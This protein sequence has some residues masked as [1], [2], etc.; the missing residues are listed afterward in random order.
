MPSS[1]PGGLGHAGHWTEGEILGLWAS[2][3]SN[4]AIQSVLPE[5]SPSAVW[6]GWLGKHMEWERQVLHRRQGAKLRTG[7]G[8]QKEVP[9]VSGMEIPILSEQQR[10]SSTDSQTPLE[11]V[12]EGQM[13]APRLDGPT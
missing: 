9:H 2:F 7:F 12:G 5:N 8:P 6:R 4:S 3:H 11:S 10:K 1:A 13:A